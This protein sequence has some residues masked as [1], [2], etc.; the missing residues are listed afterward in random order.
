MASYII[1]QVVDT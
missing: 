1:Y